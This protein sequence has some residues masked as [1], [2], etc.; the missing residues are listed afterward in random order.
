MENRYAKISEV[1]AGTRLVTDAG[2]TCLRRNV[3]RLV[4]KDELGL[5]IKCSEGNHYLDGQ[6]QGRHYIGLKVT[7]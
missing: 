1:K 7:S 5:Y 6:A 4:R 3:R 2:F